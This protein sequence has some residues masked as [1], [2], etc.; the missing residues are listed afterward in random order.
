MRI[1]KCLTLPLLLVFNF[2]FKGHF[3]LHSIHR[4]TNSNSGG[5]ANC[6][7]RKVGTTVVGPER[8]VD[9]TLRQRPKETWLLLTWLSMAPKEVLRTDKYTLNSECWKLYS[10]SAVSV[11]NKNRPL[12]CW[13]WEAASTK[14]AFISIPLTHVTIPSTIVVPF[15]PK[16]KS[17]LNPP[18][19]PQPPF[20]LTYSPLNIATN[21]FH[22]GYRINPWD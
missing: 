19:H 15:N 12:T 6:V 7:Y 22:Y 13:W 9:I 17:V 2:N 16:T 3:F 11:K 20:I 4:A 1:R 14:E 5:R 10:A 18:H 21:S 8:K